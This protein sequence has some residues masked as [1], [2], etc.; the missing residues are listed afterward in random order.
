MRHGGT[1]LGGQ[2]TEKVRHKPYCVILFDEVEKAHVDVFNLC[3]PGKQNSDD[4][5]P[6]GRMVSFKNAIIIIGG[7]HPT[8]GIWKRFSPVRLRSA[9]AATGLKKKAETGKDE[10]DV[11]SP[12][13]LN[14]ESESSIPDENDKK[15]ARVE[16]V[17]MEQVRKHF[18][19]EFV[20]RIDEFI[21]F[22]PLRQDQIHSIV[23]LRLKGVVQRL[24]EKK[25]KLE[26]DTIAVSLNEELTSS[27]SIG[28]PLV[29]DDTIVV[30]LNEELTSLVFHRVP[31]GG[32][33]PSE[34]FFPPP[35]PALPAPVATTTPTASATSSAA[36]NGSA[37]SGPK[38]PARKSAKQGTKEGAKAG[39]IT[40]TGVD[41]SQ[42]GAAARSDTST[43]PTDTG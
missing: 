21:I 41:V 7:D 27:S 30:S 12:P 14:E 26:D 17:V 40:T 38:L 13:V 23:K 11:S 22:E 43:L 10:S 16:E 19:P 8:L 9:N 35:A 31:P 42:D 3:G 5:A 28:C 39:G 34:G 15:A 36:D 20:N 6:W 4:G 1:P 24:G 37:P 29:E 25:M 2:L 33:M 32:E 18:K